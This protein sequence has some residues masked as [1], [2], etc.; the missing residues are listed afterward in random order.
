MVEEDDDACTHPLIAVGGCPSNTAACALQA[1]LAPPSLEM[2][3]MS[4]TSDL[5]PA[6]PSADPRTEPLPWPLAEDASNVD[7]RRFNETEQCLE[8]DAVAAVLE[9][10][11]AK[12]PDA[13]ALVFQGESLTYAA[14]H[15]RGNQTARYLRDQGVGADVIV[16]VSMRR[17]VEMVVTLLGIV[18]A[19]GA[20]LPLDPTWPAERLTRMIDDAGC[21]L[22]V[23]DT[24]PSPARLSL[25]EMRAS[26]LAQAT[27]ALP[28]QAGP[29]DLAYC[30]YTSGSTGAPKCATVEQ[31]GMVNMLEDARRAPGFSA[32]RWLAT[33]TLS[34]DFSVMEI[35]IPLACGGTVVLVPDDLVGDGPALLRHIE[36]HAV[37]VL[38]WPPA[39]WP[40]LLE[41]GWKGAPHMKLLSGGERLSPAMASALLARGEVY[42]YYGPCETAVY[43]AWGRVSSAEEAPIVGRPASNARI[44]IVDEQM[45]PVPIGTEGELCIGG[46]GVGRGYLHRPDLTAERFLPDPFATG[47]RMFRTGDRARWRRDGRIEV[48]GRLDDQVKLDGARIEP[49]EIEAT[50]LAH[51][52]V[53][54]AVAAV[55]DDGPRGPWLVAWVVAASSASPEPA[56]LR[57]WLRERLPPHLVP[58]AI[59]VMQTFPLLRSGKI[60][61]QALPSPSPTPPHDAT[62]PRT[63]LEETLATIFA[64]VLERSHVGVNDDF[65]A[66]GGTSLLAMRAMARVREAL[67]VRGSIRAIFDTPTVA[68]LALALLPATQTPRPPAAATDGKDAALPSFEQEQIWLAEQALSGTAAYN[69]AHGLVLDGPLEQARLQQALDSLVARHAALRTTF[70]VIDGTLTTVTAAPARIVLETE[71]ISSETEAQRVAAVEAQRPFDLAAGPLLRARLIRLGEQ[72]HLLLLVMH[73]IVCDGWSMDVIWR[74]LDA[75]YAQR[76]LEPLPL[77]YGAWAAERRETL[78]RE[79][80]DPLLAHWKTALGDLP[81]ALE[82]PTDRRRPPHASIA[83]AVTQRRL[84]PALVADIDALARAHGCSRFITMLAAFQVLLHRWCDADEFVVGTPFAGRDRV[85]TEPLVGYFVNTLALRADCTQDP[86]FDRLLEQTRATVLDAF[87][88]ADLPFPLLVEHLQP[89]R[90]VGRSPIFDVM[91]AVHA[92]TRGSRLGDLRA[93]PFSVPNGCVKLDLDLSVITSD[94]GTDCVI[95]YRADLFDDASMTGLLA[96]YETLLASIIA[97]P[98]R[99]I[100]QLA[101]TTAEE[102]RQVLEAFNPSRPQAPPPPLHHL[103]EQAAR[104]TPNAVAVS[105]EDKRLTYAELEAQADTICRRLQRLGVTTESHVGLHLPRSIDQIAAMLGVLKAGAAYVPLDPAWPAERTTWIIDDA[106]IDLVISRQTLDSRVR[107]IDPNGPDDEGTDS[108]HISSADGAAAAYLIYTSGSTGA[109]KGVVVEHGSAARYAREAAQRLG[110]ST[111][112]RLLQFASA[113]FDASIEE[114]FATLTSGATLVLRTDEMLSTMAV[115]LE[116]CNELAIS[117]LCLPTAF[118]HDLTWAMRNERLSLPPAL[119]AVII[120][121][122]RA[123]P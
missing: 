2:L 34:F 10:Q 23:C 114:I 38:S 52:S 95:E 82:L 3:N 37:N 78:N 100:G 41:A 42:N 106:L 108:A 14:L 107:V 40:V 49:G 43:C 44:Y 83:A 20:F 76:P 116:R 98:S 31:R 11:A 39:L 101:L 55:R 103:F 45:R 32:C 99:R 13:T 90:A 120:G 9:A 6:E 35:F 62:P 24:D 46:M 74:D 5:Q 61:R 80:I 115:F 73:H 18:K 4:H 30:I 21:R 16:G 36:Q 104:R 70:I 56:A 117:V 81:E 17:S 79:T 75:L 54:E 92:A 109:P 118:W 53:R 72:R 64:D 71:E 28:P 77:Q 102:R 84:P 67:G 91:F 65:F 29:H 19:G 111:G 47:A 69:E 27:V 94:E 113:S 119:R 50:L 87:S 51:A 105:H 7:L 86:R 85:E 22:V 1:R 57:G 97:T 26:V 112:D 60:D 96:C 122:E 123:M 88:N 58:S 12:T 121:G 89:Q 59:A 48:L 8:H 93:R 63:P 68:S 25:E 66:L 15:A 33:T 110:L